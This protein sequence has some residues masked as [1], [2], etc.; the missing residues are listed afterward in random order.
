MN[1]LPNYI[2][3]PQNQNEVQEKIEG[4]KSRAGF[5]RWLQR[6]MVAMSQSLD[7]GKVQK[8]MFTGRD[9]PH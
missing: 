8:I 9:F 4:V 2:N 5:P 1:V 7:L 3:V 6:S